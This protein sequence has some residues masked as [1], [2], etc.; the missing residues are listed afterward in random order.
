LLESLKFLVIITPR[1]NSKRLDASDEILIII[2]I[3]V[4]HISYYCMY[5]NL[6][7]I[8]LSKKT[9]ICQNMVAKTKNLRNIFQLWLFGIKLAHL[10]Q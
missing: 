10:L 3:V 8:S 1:T 2:N 4:L 7:A 6:K 5:T 9:N